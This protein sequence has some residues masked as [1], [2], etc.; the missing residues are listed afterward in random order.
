MLRPTPC[1]ARNPI[2]RVVLS[3][4]AITVLALGVGLA[5]T[6]ADAVDEPQ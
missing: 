5:P 3:V 4:L 1:P 6:A 2:P